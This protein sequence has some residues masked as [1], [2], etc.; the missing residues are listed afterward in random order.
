MK[1]PTWGKG[2]PSSLTRTLVLNEATRQH[3]LWRRRVVHRISSPFESAGAKYLMGADS[4]STFVR[5][6]NGLL[7]RW[8]YFGVVYFVKAGRGGAN[9]HEAYHRA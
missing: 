6:L 7:P 2:M 4:D 5:A 8:L 9:S 1:G 3:S